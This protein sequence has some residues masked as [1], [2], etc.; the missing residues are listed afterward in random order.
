MG[1]IQTRGILEGKKAREPKESKNY[2]EVKPRVSQKSISQEI[3][4]VSRAGEFS[5]SQI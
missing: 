5:E 4:E 3:L 2:G 1:S